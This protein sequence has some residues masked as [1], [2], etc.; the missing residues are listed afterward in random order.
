MATPLRLLLPWAALAL[1]AGV[2]AF[3]LAPQG[4]WKTAAG[5]LG[6]AWVGTGTLR[7]VWSRLRASGR[8]T[9]EMLGMSLAHFGI[10][11]FLVGALLVE[12]LSQQRELAVKAGDTVTLGDY[13]FR[14]DG[15]TETGGSNYV[16]DRAT[17]QVLH[18]G[19][20]TT[21]H[22]EKRRY[23]AS[24]QVM[25]ESGIARGVFADAYVAIGEALGNDTWAMRVH[26]K[27]FV[28]WI[29]AGALLM[30]LGAGVT[31]FDRRFR[32]ARKDLQ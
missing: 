32:S 11:V 25:T 5:V 6:A 7:F 9:R 31:A 29:W 23:R 22:P 1:V 30:A 2:V 18:G 28:R 3:F 8:M 27:P 4:Q 14:F 20:S 21:L 17:V 13:A 15:I 26:V 12:G 24:G 16:S 19:D 10:A